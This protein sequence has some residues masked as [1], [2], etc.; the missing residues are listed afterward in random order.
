MPILTRLRVAMPALWVGSYGADSYLRAFLP[1]V[2]R[3]DSRAEF[4]VLIPETME[5]PPTLGRNVTY[6]R[7]PAMDR[8]GRHFRTLWEQYAL[9]RLL[10]RLDVD[11]VYTARNIGLLRSRKPCVIA[12][13]NM[14]PLVP[15]FGREVW[16]LRFNSIVRRA[17]SRASIRAARRV[18]AVSQYVKDVLVGM[19]TDAGKIDVVYHGVDDVPLSLRED[20]A[21]STPYVAAVSITACSNARR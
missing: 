3:Y 16:S 13:R 11:V 6:I 5:R 18:V 21:S 12:V 2:D 9:P 14:D 19:G 17:L 10:D 1:A 8:A 20:G 4:V 7:I 15:K